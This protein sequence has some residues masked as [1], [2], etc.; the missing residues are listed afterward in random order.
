MSP[1]VFE[2]ALVVLVVVL[3]VDLQARTPNVNNRTA[4]SERSIFLVPFIDFLQRLLVDVGASAP[5]AI[6]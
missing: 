4:K 3:L 5:S 6:R 2:L 1:V